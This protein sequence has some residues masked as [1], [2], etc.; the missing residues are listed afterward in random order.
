[1]K[2]FR[3]VVADGFMFTFNAKLLAL[4]LLSS[5]PVSSRLSTGVR[6]PSVEVGEVGSSL[7]HSERGGSA[8]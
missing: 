2:R 1:M 3:A 7:V 5:K 4:S 8:K 6:Q